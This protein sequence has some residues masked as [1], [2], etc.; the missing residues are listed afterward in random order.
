MGWDLRV[1]I[2]TLAQCRR[3]VKAGILDPGKLHVRIGLARECVQEGGTLGWDLVPWQVG[4]VN[5]ETMG[6]EDGNEDLAS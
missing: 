2:R 5:Q 4:R 3:G 1:S 6:L